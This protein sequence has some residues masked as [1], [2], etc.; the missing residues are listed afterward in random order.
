MKTVILETLLKLL[1]PIFIVFALYMF[2]RGHDNPGGGFIAGLI[3]VI[4]VMIH[5]IAYSS[6]ETIKKYHIKPIL[7][8]VCGLFLAALSGTVGMID[9]AP[10][11]T[12]IWS[13]YTIPLLGKV[14]TPIL[15]DLGVMLIVSG[16]VLKVTFLFSEKYKL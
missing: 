5:S 14:G 10:F 12:S 2:V 1:I 6:E 11:M 3:V 9:G 15:F 16:M 13:E 7:M 8:T 4:P